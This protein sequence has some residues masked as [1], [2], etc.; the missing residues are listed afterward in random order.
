M[1]RMATMATLCSGC[2]DCNQPLGDFG[3]TSNY[4]STLQALLATKVP[5]ALSIVKVIK[6]N[7]SGGKVAFIISRK[8]LPSKA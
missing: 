8:T 6:S 3:W 4:K 5:L 7:G 1:S 2:I